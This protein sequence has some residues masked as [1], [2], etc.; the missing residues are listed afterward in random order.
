MRAACG[1]WVWQPPGL[2]QEAGALTLPVLLCAALSRLHP[3]HGFRTENV[4]P[5]Y[6]PGWSQLPPILNGRPEQ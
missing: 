5:L 6:F 1:T 3:S 2:G 4:L